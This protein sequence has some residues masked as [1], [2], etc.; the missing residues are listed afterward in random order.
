MPKLAGRRAKA[1]TGNEYRLRLAE[2]GKKLTNLGVQF[3]RS[4]QVEPGLGVTNHYRRY[5]LT[6]L[7]SADFQHLLT[8]LPITDENRDMGFNLSF[9]HTLLVSLGREQLNHL[10]TEQVNAPGDVIFHEGEP[11]DSMYIIRSGMLAIVKGDWAIPTFLGYRGPGDVVGE[12]ALLEDQPRSASG[13]ILKE[14]TLMRVRR[15]DFQRMLREH[16]DLGMNIM[17]IMSKRLRTSDNALHANSQD[18]QRLVSQVS[19]LQTEKQ[20]LLEL[21]RLREETSDL[22]VHD[23]RNPLNNIL[24]M[25]H[26]LPV[27]LP[28]QAWQENREL[29]E[30]AQAS[31]ERMRML[32]DSLLSVARMENGE[33]KLEPTSLYLPTLVES[34]TRRMPVFARGDL[35]LQINHSPALPTIMADQDM[36]DRVLT[37]LLDNAVKHTPVGS[38][39][40]VTLEEQAENLL[41]S[42]ADRGPGIPA[43]ERERIFERFSQTRGEK[44]QRRGFGLGLT[45][46]RLAIEAHNGKI[47]V[48]AGEG[49]VGSKF[50]FALPLRAA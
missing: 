22:I 7:P 5:P 30:S 44:R 6:A 37:N 28:E 49:G 17:Q 31:C 13:V 15:D 26:L 27:T 3:Y 35:K 36:L 4:E 14:S 9:L 40:T 8:T 21:Q 19:T 11:G 1:A 10:I 46:C 32:I 39:V 38:Q 33:T 12:M 34:A 25:L 2:H 45:F 18:A 42:V 16:P 50:V 47:W 48:E 23:L 20:Q 41:V 24:W 43:D 29:L